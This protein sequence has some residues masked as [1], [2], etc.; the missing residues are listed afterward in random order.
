MLVSVVVLAYLEEPWF[1]RSVAAIL[2]STGV[3]IEVII[4]DN[5]ET[6][7]SVKRLEGSDSRIHVLHPG[8][9][10]GFAGGCNLGAAHAQGEVI[11]FINGDALV[12]PEAVAALASALEDPGVGIATAS[13]RLADE[14]DKINSV[15][16]AVHFL[17]LCWAGGVGDPVGL[18]TEPKSAPSASGA[19]MA[20]SRKIWE[21]LEGFEETF[22]AYYEDTDLS[23]RC[24]QLGLEVRYVPDSVVLH[25]YEFS[26]N[27]RKLYLDERNRLASL[28]TL[29]ET[30]TLALLAPAIL[31][32]E[33]GLLL[34]A[35]KESWATEK[36]RGW[37]WLV[38]NVKWLA[39]R[40][41][42]VQERRQRSDQSLVPIFS[43]RFDSVAFSLSGPM[44]LGN[45]IL[46]RYWR[47]VVRWI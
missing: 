1:E 28:L 8:S 13:I 18:H 32:F 22:F 14:P 36:V 25:R 33:A 5:G 39:S 37:L 20:V 11:A 27:K 17:G 45:R 42:K 31:M 4:V 41:R 19:A 21:A 47:L 29:Y 26:R 3:E 6:A 7:G 44:E 24:W 35:V 46:D 2:A 30:R 15:G 23:L 43:G 10:L 12:E 9:N 38:A 34:L 16:N 40:R